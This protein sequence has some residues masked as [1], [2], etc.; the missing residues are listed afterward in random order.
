MLTRRHLLRNSLAALSGAAMAGVAGCGMPG[1]P[2]NIP[3][4]LLDSGAQLGHRL[5]SRTGG[6][7]A[8]GLE[9][10]Q[11]RPAVPGAAA[12][13]LPPPSL[14]R[15][16]RVVIAGAGIAGL[17]AARTLKN[18]GVDDV[19]LIDALDEVGGNSSSGRNDVSAYPWGAHY[20]PLVRSDCQPV[21]DLFEDLKIIVDQDDHG[22][23]IYDEY[24]LSADPQER[25]WMYGRWQEGLVP[26]L[27]S[28]ARD[29][30]EFTAFFAATE[31]LKSRLGS[32][33]KPVFAIPIDASSADPAWRA[34]DSISITQYLRQQGYQSEPLHWYVNYC[35]RDDYGSLATGVSAWAGL[36]YFA[37]RNGVAANADS[38]TV[39]TWPEGNGHLA[40]ELTRQAAA[41]QQCNS[42]VTRV[43]RNGS[44]AIVEYFDTRL[45]RTVRVEADAAIICLPRFIATRI[46]EGLD[47]ADSSG[48]SYA[49]WMVANLTLSELPAGRG[50]ALAWDNV[51]YDSSLL[52]YVVATHQ[53]LDTV[54][55]N[56]VITYYW[57]LSDQDPAAAR[58]T[59][60]ERNLQ[61][62]QAYIVRDLLRVHPELAA[63]IENIDVRVWGHAMI[64][65]TPGFIW[66]DARRAAG[67]HQPPLYFAH[68]DLS[69]ISIFEEAYCRGHEA[70]RLAAERLVRGS[71]ASVSGPGAS[72]NAGNT[73]P[74]NA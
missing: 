45:N 27:G 54:R 66:G 29:R 22:R 28:T 21:L 30:A 19:L 65:P 4:R 55:H 34:L 46:V 57:P 70:G 41:Q 13:A 37:A 44:G 25:L 38:T 5:W 18:A 1:T 20:V 47:A 33:G 67:V 74:V 15:R 6:G 61:D 26:Q 71:S 35:C 17:A 43:A 49:P 68:S 24:C 58:K 2:R 62:W 51:I 52:G 40:H 11:A 31:Q 42:L 8:Q 14:T 32:D 36:H 64:R 50:Q 69:G 10:G 12:S 56:T 23:P 9:A 53:S 63:H 16:A 59:A 72:V 39:V 3:G 73:T 60:L 7:P 48:F